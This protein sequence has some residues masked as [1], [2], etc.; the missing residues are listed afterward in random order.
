MHTGLCENDSNMLRRKIIQSLDTWHAMPERKSLI[1]EGPQEIGK[2]FILKSFAFQNYKQV[3]MINFNQFPYMRH[4]FK[5]D[6][7]VDGMVLQMV[8]L[9]KGAVC[10]PFET[11]IL[12]EE[13]E[14]CPSAY[15]AMKKFSFDKRYDCIA[16]LSRFNFLEPCSEI[17][18]IRMHSLDYEEFLWANNMSSNILSQVHQSFSNN[19]QISLDLHKHLIE[20]FRTYLLVGGMPKAVKSYLST[21][22]MDQV[23]KVHKLIEESYLSEMLMGVKQK[24]RER[25]LHL[26]TSIPEQIARGNKRFMY[27]EVNDK[28]THRNYFKSIQTMYRMGWA[29]VVYKLKSTNFP[30]VENR[31]SGNFIYMLRDVGCLSGQLDEDSLIKYGDLSL[32]QHNPYLMNGVADILAKRNIKMYFAEHGQHDFLVA[33]VGKQRIGLSYENVKT[34]R[35][36]KRLVEKGL[37]DACYNL[38][39]HPLMVDKVGIHLPLYHL[40]FI[41]K[42]TYEEVRWN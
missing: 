29:F 5:M 32:I 36:M 1:I 31:T 11:L 20:M 27:K 34:L 30:L 24:D 33:M 26:Y 40:M 18:K 12:M 42:G 19:E 9:I 22:D 17:D 3:V 41:G 2:T 23:R 6:M 10:I 16:T 39:A 13:L 35:K 21:Q 38:T 14:Y 15:E 25:F 4:L 37:L 8:M 7:D 28:A